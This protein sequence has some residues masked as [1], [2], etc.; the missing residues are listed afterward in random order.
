M[1]AFTQLN[2]I[3]KQNVGQDKD[4]NLLWDKFWETVGDVKNKHF[5]LNNNKEGLKEIDLIMKITHAITHAC[6]HNKDL[7][8]STLN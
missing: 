7:A 3:V 8:Y 2:W 6:T 1:F 4:K 5:V